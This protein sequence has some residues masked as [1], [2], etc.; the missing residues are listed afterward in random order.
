MDEIKNPTNIKVPENLPTEEDSIEPEEMPVKP[1]VVRARPAKPLVEGIN[2]P[3]TI[4]S[5]IKSPVEQKSGSVLTEAEKKLINT[6]VVKQSVNE[7]KP[8]SQFMPA[9]KKSHFRVLGLLVVGLILAGIAWA[10]VMWYQ[11]RK[12]T[13]EEKKVVVTEP[14]KNTESENS[15]IPTPVATSTEVSTSTPVE[16][17]KIVETMKD[18]KEL[19]IKDTPT[20]FLNVRETPSASGVLITKVSPGAIFTYKTEKSG[21]Y[22]IVLP[23]NKTGWVIGQYV[24]KIVRKD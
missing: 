16:L 10:G 22:E 20:G 18:V 11:N 21:W 13:L 23:E 3:V 15:V 1:K 6:P 8:M 2:S 24:E 17:P 19:K 7:V 12:I 9:K 14:I 4:K 5:E